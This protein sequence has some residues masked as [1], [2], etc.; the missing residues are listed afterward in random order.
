MVFDIDMTDYDDVRTCCSAA[1]ICRKCWPLMT[2]AM[3]VIDVGLRED[4]GFKHL[5]W[6]YSGRRGIHCWVCDKRARQLSNEGRS[7]VAEYFSVYKGTDASGTIKK[8]ALSTPLH[9][10]L[11]RAYTDVLK[12]YWTAGPSKR[13]GFPDCLRIVDQCTR[14]HSPHP[15]PWPGHLFPDCLLILYWCT[16]THSLHPTNLPGHSIPF[17]P[18]QFR[19]TLVSGV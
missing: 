14:T 2:V 12:P 11:A 19:R 4:F 6:V 8:V 13:P 3:K 17:H 5:L 18:P 1:A 7:A 15:P 9:P 10:S 16:L